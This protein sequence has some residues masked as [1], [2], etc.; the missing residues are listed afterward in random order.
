VL[1]TFI[2]ETIDGDVIGDPQ[3]SAGMAVPRPVA[4]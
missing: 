4:L 1:K 3:H 2:R